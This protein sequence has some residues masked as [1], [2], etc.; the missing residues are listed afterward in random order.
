MAD[1]GILIK[2]QQATKSFPVWRVV[3]VID[4]CQLSVLDHCVSKYNVRVIAVDLLCI[5]L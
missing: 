3:A 1:L 4:I 5:E 2:A